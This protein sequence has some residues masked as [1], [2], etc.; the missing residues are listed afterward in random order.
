MGWIT[1][2]KVTESSELQKIFR[3]AQQTKTPVYLYQDNNITDGIIL[4]LSNW[5]QVEQ[6]D[7][8]N[9]MILVPPGLLL[10]DLNAIAN[11]KGLRFIPADTPVFENLSVG[12]WAYRGCPN[13]SAWKY[14]AGKHF[15][16]GSTYVFPN[17]DLTTVGGKCIKNVT[18]YDFTRFL[19]GPYADL[20]VGVQYIIKLMPEPANKVTFQVEFDSLDDA[21]RLV[22]TLQGRPVPPAWLFWLDKTVGA[23]LGYKMGG[24][25]RLIFELDGNETEVSQYAEDIQA[26]L[27]DYKAAVV[28]EPAVLPDMA[29]VEKRT[30]EFWLLD[31][32]KVS[33]TE[34]PGFVAQVKHILEKNRYRG[35][36]FGQLADGKI[37]LFIDQ[38]RDQ[39]EDIV[40]AMQNAVQKH[41]GVISGKYRRLYQGGVNGK[42]KDLEMMFKQRMDPAGIFNQTKEAAQ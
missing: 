7:A 17:G 16:L 30:K 40:T 28:R 19:T 8:D 12:E 31:E 20:A 38:D 3:Q 29:F 39:V 18:G 14:G 24:E 23:K 41:G 34:A 32:F 2:K 33:Y 15:L 22:H 9:L 26:I 11:G 21:S 27:P 13:L 36:L 5:N 10:K 1:T 25:H 4:D 35:G 37:H 42:L 6:F